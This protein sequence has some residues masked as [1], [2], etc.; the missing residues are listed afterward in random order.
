MPLDPGAAA[1]AAPA[2]S[3]TTPIPGGEID[4]DVLGLL[5][6]DPASNEGATLMVFAL[7]ALGV[8]V[9]GL[10]V[11]AWLHRPSRYDAA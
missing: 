1:D 11:R 3:T 6:P 5:P 8:F 4:V 9:A 7:A 10:G 2:T